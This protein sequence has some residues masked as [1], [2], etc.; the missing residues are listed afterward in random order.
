[1]P[2][3]FLTAW[4]KGKKTPEVMLLTRQ[5]S[6]IKFKNFDKN[7]NKTLTSITIC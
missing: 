2:G 7:V 3:A 1:M 4:G 6:M 5:G